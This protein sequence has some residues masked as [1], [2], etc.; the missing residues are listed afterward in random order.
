MSESI[1]RDLL[2]E[3]KDR[4]IVAYDDMQWP[5]INATAAEI[6]EH[7]AMGKTN[8]SHVK[9]GAAHAVGNLKRQGLKTML[10]SKYHDIPKTVELS[11]YEAT[12]AEASVVTVHASG[13]V[14]MLKAAVK[15][16]DTSRIKFIEE[17]KSQ[18]G[19]LLGITVLTSLEDE[20]YSIFG[21]DPEDKDAI[22]KKVLDFAFKACDTGV[23]GIVCSAEEVDAVKSHSRLDSLLLVTP[24][25][26]PSYAEKAHDQK[27]TTG[28]KEAIERGADMLVVGRGITQ[29]ERYGLTKPEAAQ[30]VNQEIKEGLGK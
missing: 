19:T 14:D 20:A 6:A 21:L 7:T 29:A 17:R 30:A 2:I 10:D 13:G 15:G 12:E 27:R 11:I 24:G 25:I 22:R 5:E 26:T 3:P 18:V 28:V 8:S 16:R 23:D 1:P 9:Y 4:L